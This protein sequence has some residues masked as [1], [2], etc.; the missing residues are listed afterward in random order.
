MNQEDNTGGGGIFGLFKWTKDALFGTDISPS[1][2]YK[3][4]EERRD[5]S[6]YAQDDTNFSMKFG[7]DSNRR[8]T[9]LSRSNSWSGLDST[10]HRKYELLPEYNENGF[11][12][13]VNGD[14]HS[15][16]RIRSLRSPAPIVPREPLRNEPTD[17]FGHR[18]HTKRRTINELSNSQIPF[19]PPQE[20]DPL[21][22]KLFNKD[23]VNEVRRSP[24][25]LSVKDIPGKFP[26]PLTKRDEIDNYYV[27]DEDA[28]HKNREYKKAY[29]DLF[30]QMDLNSRDLEDLC[31]DVREQREQFLRNEQ[32]YK[33][34][35]EE[36]RAELVN[37]LKKSKTLF[38]NY[39]SLGQKYKSLKKVLDQTISHEAELATSRERLYQEEDL[40][41][42]EI[43]TLKQRLSD[44]EL[45]YTNLQ[46]EKDMQRDNYESEIHDLLLQ[47]SLRNN[48]RKDT[49][50][51]SNIFST[52]QYDRTPFHNGNN[53]YDSNSHSWDTDY[54]KNIDGFI[55]R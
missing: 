46:I 3:D 49:S 23:G 9:N 6:R 45:K 52:G 1:M 44:L 27:R 39:Y 31:E 7:N 51:G 4:Q 2:K 12:S 54:L 19:I 53:S 40:K 35:Y 20:D 5:R 36:M 34:A 14:H 29:F 17:T 48:E 22:S 11:N 43:Q 25:K 38:E 47:L 41:N 24:Y 30:A 13:I 18:L 32:T 50:A 42:F 26:S 8:S 55:E 33:Q 37:E 10:L 15:K 16:E 28:C 21:L